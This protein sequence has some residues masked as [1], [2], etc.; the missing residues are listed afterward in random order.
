MSDSEGNSS[1]SDEEVVFDIPQNDSR[2]PFLKINKFNPKTVVI[3]ED[4]D[5]IDEDDDDDDADEVDEDDELSVLGTKKIIKSKKND[6]DEESDDEEEESDDDDDFDIENLDITDKKKSKK[7]TKKGDT[8]LDDYIEN[9]IHSLV[10]TD[11][12]DMDDEPEEDEDYL[13]KFNDNIRKNVI[14]D[15]H[16]EL[17]QISYEEIEAL[18][19]ITKN[20]NGVIIDP[21]HRTLPFLTK[22]EKARI[23]GERAKQLNA[24]AK[25]FI[26]L[27]PTIID[28]YIIAVKELEEKKIPFIIKRPLPNG[29]CEYWKLKDLEIL[30]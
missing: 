26:S 7:S 28:G 27:D 18:S 23:L 30:I 8:N 16:P 29:G 17:N 20:E 22:Y 1:E 4:A 3:K 13:Q 21:L 25:A 19:V 10:D 5:E 11:D 24:G 15:Y 9:D 6:Y 12:D 14:S 2:K